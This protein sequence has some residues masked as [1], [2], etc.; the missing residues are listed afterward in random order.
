MFFSMLQWL[1]RLGLWQKGK[2]PNE[3]WKPS[4]QASWSGNDWGRRSLG[5]QP[6]RTSFNSCLKAVHL[7][8]STKTLPCLLD[9]TYFLANAL[10]T[11]S[12]W[13]HRFDDRSWHRVRC[14]WCEALQRFEGITRLVLYRE[15]KNGERALEESRASQLQNL[16]AIRQL[17]EKLEDLEDHNLELQGTVTNLMT[18]V[19]YRKWYVALACCIYHKLWQCRY[20]DKSA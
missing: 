12:Y 2:H 17:G 14:T 18:E 1:L 13:P 9:C 6:H 5:R 19:S 16:A 8:C 11:S 10:K 20:C 7:F 15:D 4:L 3:S